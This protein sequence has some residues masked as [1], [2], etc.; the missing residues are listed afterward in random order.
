MIDKTNNELFSSIVRY[1]K[2]KNNES[3]FLKLVDDF[4]DYLNFRKWI[5]N[6]EQ[7]RKNGVYDNYV[8]ECSEKNEFIR[9]FNTEGG[10]FIFDNTRE[11]FLVEDELID[12]K[13]GV[14]AKRL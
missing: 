7:I 8:K 11:E 10:E 4:S 9:K 13:V 5:L 2:N 1:K 12:M 14:K 3:L 6:K